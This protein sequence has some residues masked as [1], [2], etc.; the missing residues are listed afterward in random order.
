[1]A[2]V[3]GNDPACFEVVLL[4]EI[5][6]RTGRDWLS[7][8]GPEKADLGLELVDSSHDLLTILHRWE[9]RLTP[10]GGIWLF[11][12]K[13]GQNGYI[14]QRELIEMGKL[15]SLVD[16]KSCSVSENLSGLRFV[17]RKSQRPT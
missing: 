6:A 5:K 8:A 7:G 12:P 3:L 2:V 1:M 16:N 11:T 17:I 4:A 13:R 14:D 10:A 9:K 15:T